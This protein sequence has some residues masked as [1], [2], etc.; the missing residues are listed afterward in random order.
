M[1]Q[2]S[3]IFSIES[4]QG[5]SKTWQ[6][7]PLW[8]PLADIGANQIG[9]LIEDRNG[10]GENG[11]VR[12]RVY[13]DG[14][15]YH[16]DWGDGTSGDYDDEQTVTHTY[17]IGSGTASNTNTTV[18]KAKITSAGNIERFRL[19]NDSNAIEHTVLVIKLNTPYFKSCENMAPYNPNLLWC[20]FACD[21]D[22]LTTLVS[23]FYYTV[24]LKRVD[25]PDSMAALTTL[26]EAFSLSSIEELI[27][28]I[29]APGITTIEEMCYQCLVLKRAVM[30]NSMPL[31]NTLVNAFAYCC[32]LHEIGFPTDAGSNAAAVNGTSAFRRIFAKNN[33]IATPNMKYSA[34]S[35]EGSASKL[36]GIKGIT[37]SSASLFAGASPQINIAY[38][39]MDSTAITA[40][41]NTLP[42]LT[43]KTINITGALG[44][45]GLTAEDRAIATGKGWTITG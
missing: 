44:T 13:T 39:S 19:Y 43:G 29:N 33:G 14:A 41:F 24:S 5:Y 38:T 40:V 17:S 10:I 18:Y 6:P 45:S 34:I 31:L 32:M 8:P 4:T 25:F 30:P 20:I 22:S 11:A 1:I 37:F 28:P 7:D 2:T 3:G 27:L 16:V 21:M 23:A 35:C 15:D 9:L 36:S 26:Y 12:L 42:T